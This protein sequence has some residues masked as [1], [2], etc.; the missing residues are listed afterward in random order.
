MKKFL[1]V[2]FQHLVHIY[3]DYSTADIFEMRGEKDCP[4]GELE[5]EFNI[6]FFLFFLGLFDVRM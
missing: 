2:V 3:C 5:R 1:E 6:S 4:S